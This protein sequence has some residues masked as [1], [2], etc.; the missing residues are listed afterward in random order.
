MKYEI[1]QYDELYQ[2]RDNDIRAS[3]TTNAPNKKQA[4]QNILDE[5]GI[6]ATNGFEIVKEFG[7][8]RIKKVVE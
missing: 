5:V 1:L 4:L 8:Y 6:K 3:F 7:F 2:F